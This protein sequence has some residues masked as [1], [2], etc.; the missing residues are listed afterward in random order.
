MWGRARERQHKGDLENSQDLISVGCY[1]L[2]RPSMFLASLQDLLIIVKAPGKPASG[3]RSRPK[4][5][6]YRTD[7]RR[8][9]NHSL[10]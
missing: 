7:A 3:A 1:R 9:R 8:R 5:E 2:R 10:A 4:Q 6:G